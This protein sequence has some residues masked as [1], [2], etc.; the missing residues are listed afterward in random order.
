[1]LSR[2]PGQTPGRSGRFSRAPGGFPGPPGSVPGRSDSLPGVLRQLKSFCSRRNLAKRPASFLMFRCRA[3]T[4]SSCRADWRPHIVERL[5]S[6]LPLFRIFESRSGRSRVGPS[7]FSRSLSTERPSFNVSIAP[8]TG[9]TAERISRGRSGEP[10]ATLSKL[11]Q[12]HMNCS[13]NQSAL[14]N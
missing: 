9:P 5:S 11:A 12:F 1:M 6:L 2:T 8:S 14:E 10:S 4:V 7:A 13:N 3:S